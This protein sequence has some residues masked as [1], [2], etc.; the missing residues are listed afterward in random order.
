[1]KE[2]YGMTKNKMNQL[3]IETQQEERKKLWEERGD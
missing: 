3:G 2:T 1:M